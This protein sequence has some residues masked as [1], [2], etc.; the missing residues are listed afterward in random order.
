MFNIF[1][2]EMKTASDPDLSKCADLRNHF[3]THAHQLNRM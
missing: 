2:F 3:Q 1:I